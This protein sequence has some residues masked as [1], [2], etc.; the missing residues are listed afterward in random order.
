MG[1]RSTRFKGKEIWVEVDAEGMPEVNGGR[2]TTRYSQAA[3][4]KLYRA[5]AAGIS[6]PTGPVLDLPPGV[7]ADAAPAAGSGSPAARPA[8]KA[9]PGSGFGKAG[10]RTAA[11]GAMAAEAARTV[12][13]SK[14]GVKA[15][16]IPRRDNVPYKGST[17][18]SA[19]STSSRPFVWTS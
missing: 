16:M 8:G 13:T 9:R 11:Q 3:G 17:A 18:A 19:G 14:R 5:G 12:A 6:A 1:W 4:V 7:P 2:V 15:A 10:E